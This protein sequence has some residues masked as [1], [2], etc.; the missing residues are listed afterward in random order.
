MKI[1]AIVDSPGAGQR[2]G[3]VMVKK[4]APPGIGTHNQLHLVVKSEA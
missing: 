1:R 3:N 2:M 4:D